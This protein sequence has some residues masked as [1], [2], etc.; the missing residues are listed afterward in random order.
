MSRRFQC[1]QPGANL[2]AV[3]VQ[4]VL[5]RS[6]QGRLPLVQ[7]DPTKSKEQRQAYTQLGQSLS[8]INSLEPGRF[9]RRD[10]WGWIKKLPLFRKN[11]Q[12]AEDTVIK[13]A[14]DEFYNRE[15]ALCLGGMKKPATDLLEALEETIINRL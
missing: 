1:W 11:D 12:N 14:S 5:P 3:R 9:L 2:I 7:D 15:L 13:A 10:R 4:A 8:R 6:T